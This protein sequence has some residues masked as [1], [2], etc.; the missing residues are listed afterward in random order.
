MQR[1][2]GSSLTQGYRPS[3]LIWPAWYWGAT[4]AFTLTDVEAMRRDY[5]VWLCLMMIKAPIFTAEWAIKC[6][7]PVISRFISEQLRSFWRPSIQKILRALEYG[8]ACGELLY[9]LNKKDQI[10]FAGYKEFHPRDVRVLTRGYE[11]TGIRVKNVEQKGDVNLYPPKGFWFATNREFGGWYGR[12]WLLNCWEP[13]YEKRSRDGAIEI[14]RMWFY[15]NAYG[16]GIMRHPNKDYVMPDGTIYPARD[17]A[18]EQVEKFKTGHVMTL[19]ATKD[20]KGQY[21]W[22]FEPPKMYGE[23]QGIREYPEELN[24]EISRGL[25][26]P[27]SVL[28]DQPGTGSYA[29]RR[30]PERAFYIQ[31]EQLLA[32]VIEAIRVQFLNPLVE[33][34]FGKDYEFEI[35]TKS[36]ADTNSPEGTP[37]VGYEAGQASE[38][39]IGGLFSEGSFGQDTGGAKGAPEGSMNMSNRLNRYAKRFYKMYHDNPGVIY[40]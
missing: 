33:L 24:R 37:P 32:E 31:L 26:I 39:A 30:V 3:T 27:D 36:I 11:Y 18:R 25:R 4:G 14:R 7:N 6:D 23:P 21:I 2:I 13:W 40:A 17:L 38:G 28:V 34:N 16:G 22:D 15:K 5:Q 9:K 20:E 35:E 8:Y 12:S 10:V 29:G 19:P 1:L